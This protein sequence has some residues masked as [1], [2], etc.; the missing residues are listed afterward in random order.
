MHPSY[1]TDIAKDQEDLT[2][3]EISARKKFAVNF[4]RKYGD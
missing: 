3:S 1:K 4:I 2:K